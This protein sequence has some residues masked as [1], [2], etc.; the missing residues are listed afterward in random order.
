MRLRCF[1]QAGMARATILSGIDANKTYIRQYDLKRE[2]MIREGKYPVCRR[3]YLG[4]PMPQ[5]A[6]PPSAVL[7]GRETISDGTHC[8]HWVY[9]GYLPPLPLAACSTLFSS[10]SLLS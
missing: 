9:E 2:Y 4:E 7:Q 6:Y 1:F 3:S 10:C 5:P 8:N